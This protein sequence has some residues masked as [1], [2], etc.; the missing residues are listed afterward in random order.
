[1]GQKEIRF[2]DASWYDEALKYIKSASRLFGWYLDVFPIIP[3]PGEPP[4]E[5]D[6][7]RGKITGEASPNYI[8]H[9]SA[10]ARIKESLP[11]VKIIFMLRNPIDRLWSDKKM[12]GETQ[13]SLAEARAKRKNNNSSKPLERKSVERQPTFEELVYYSKA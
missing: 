10:P 13:E 5:W 4:N 7:A 6:S 3:A 9:E 2:F 8:N 11:A 12:V 1:M